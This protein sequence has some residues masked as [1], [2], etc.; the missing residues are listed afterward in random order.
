M[1]IRFSSPWV[2]KMWSDL[3]KG[4]VFHVQQFLSGALK[5]HLYLIVGNE[6]GNDSGTKDRLPE[7]VALGKGLG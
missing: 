2:K 1:T 6:F 7:P 4:S 5:E 3:F